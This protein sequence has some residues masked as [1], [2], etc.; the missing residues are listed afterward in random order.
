[1]NREQIAPASDS[2]FPDTRGFRAIRWNC[3]RLK[4]VKKYFQVH[5]SP[6]SRPHCRA[7]N[8]SNCALKITKQNT[9][10]KFF[11]SFSILASLSE[12]R[13]FFFFLHIKIINIALY[14]LALKEQQRT[15]ILNT[16]HRTFP[17][18]S[19]NRGLMVFGGSRSGLF[20]FF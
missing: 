4:T 8:F 2:D 18:D 13:F 6:R 15:R 12:L 1:M 16:V 19:S 20:L 5:F 14:K 7:G 11:I 3:R 17:P 9:R 10:R